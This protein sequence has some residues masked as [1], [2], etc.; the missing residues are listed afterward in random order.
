[1]FNESERVTVSDPESDRGV[2]TEV[3]IVRSQSEGDQETD[4]GHIYGTID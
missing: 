2:Q 3:E 4:R 1:M